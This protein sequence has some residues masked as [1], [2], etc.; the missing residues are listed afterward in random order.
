M[1]TRIVCIAGLLALTAGLGGCSS[2]PRWD[3]RFG[4]A[5]RSALAAQ[6]IDPAAVRN[7]RPVTGLDGKTAAAAQERYQHSAEAPA[8]LAPLAI[9]GGV[10]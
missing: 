9:G 7:T 8:A 3:A 6:V 1:N 4:Q 2:T 10:K 5:V